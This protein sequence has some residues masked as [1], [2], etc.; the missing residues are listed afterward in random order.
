MDATDPTHKLLT[1]I[2]DLQ[3][4]HLQEYKKFTARALGTQELSVQRQEAH[5]VLYKRVLV[6]GG[7]LILGLVVFLVLLVNRHL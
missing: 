1:E 7:I 2:R 4:E 6:A 5:L 3:H